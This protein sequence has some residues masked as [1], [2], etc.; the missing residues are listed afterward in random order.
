MTLPTNPIALAGNTV[1]ADVFKFTYDSMTNAV[2]TTKPSI[3][4]GTGAPTF[5]AAQGSMYI[6][7]DGGINTRIYINTTGSTTWTVMSNAA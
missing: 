7:I 2:S 1:E 6:R 5:A 3:S 4:S